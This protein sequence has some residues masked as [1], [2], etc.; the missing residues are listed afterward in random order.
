[1]S[2]YKNSHGIN[3]NRKLGEGPRQT[4]TNL[5]VLLKKT[6]EFIG[7]PQQETLNKMT[8]TKLDFINLLCKGFPED[9]YISAR[10]HVN[11]F[12]KPPIQ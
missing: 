11:H 1:M 12:W 10:H 4:L 9:I 2:R 6:E 7:P 8:P 3:Q 5:S